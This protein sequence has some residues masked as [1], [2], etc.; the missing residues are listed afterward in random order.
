MLGF[1]LVGCRVD[2]MLGQEPFAISL[3]VDGTPKLKAPKQL[4]G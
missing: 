4:D 2:E 3:F 1:G